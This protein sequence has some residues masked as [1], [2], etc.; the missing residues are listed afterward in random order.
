M[1]GRAYRGCAP[2]LH[3][4]SWRSSSA[5]PAPAQD[6]LRDRNQ[7]ANRLFEQGEFEQALRAYG[8]LLAGRPD[9]PELAYN[10][11]NTLHRLGSFERAVEETRRALPPTTV[12]L[13]AATYFALGNHF[14]GLN[15]LPNAFEAFKSALLLVPNDADAKWNLEV[16]LLLMND[17]ALPP[18]PLPAGGQPADQPPQPGAPG[19]EQP[20]QTPTGE[21][22]GPPSQPPSDQAPA[23]AA[24]IARQLEEALAGI[25]EDFSFEDAIEVLDLLQELRDQRRTPGGQTTPSGPDY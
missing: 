3:S 15:D 9:L 14:L 19:V 22:S 23:S 18:V 4:S 2:D 10:A 7:A 21:P 8:E 16:V 20:G 1:P 24:D 11:G 6:P 12:T 17:R 25:N 13:G 5:A